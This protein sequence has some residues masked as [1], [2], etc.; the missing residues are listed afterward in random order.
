MPTNHLP[1]LQLLALNLAY[2]QQQ[3]TWDPQSHSLRLSYL[4]WLIIFVNPLT[5]ELDAASY[6]H[7]NSAQLGYQSPPSQNDQLPVTAQNQ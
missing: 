2:L 4:P 6:Q 1:L 3:N 5:S 7:S